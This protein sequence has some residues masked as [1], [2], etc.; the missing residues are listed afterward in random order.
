MKNKDKVEQS[1]IS[2]MICLGIILQDPSHFFP[3]FNV[4]VFHK[5]LCKELSKSIFIT[6]IS[7]IFS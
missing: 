2:Q 1:F 7:R 6:K 4:K 3:R 5:I